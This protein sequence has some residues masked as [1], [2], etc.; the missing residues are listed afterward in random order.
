[1]ANKILGK[2]YQYTV[3]FEPAEE[4]GYV[5]NVPA[6][7]GCVTQGDTFEEALRM[8]KDAIECYLGSKIKHQEPIPRESKSKFIK[9]VKV[10]LP[11]KT[12]A[13]R[14]F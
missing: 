4:G 11:D 10:H 14:T 1:M 3:V 5:V 6:L 12:I 2:I 8:A 7:P 9:I 13:K